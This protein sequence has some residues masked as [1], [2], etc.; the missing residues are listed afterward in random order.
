MRDRM[1]FFL[2]TSNRESANSTIDAAFQGANGIGLAGKVT[3]FT[4]SGFGRTFRV[5]ANAG[6]GHGWGSHHLVPGSAVAG[7]RFYG[8]YPNLTMGG[9]DD[10]GDDGPWIPTTS[11]EQYG[12][13]LARWFGVP[14][15]RLSQV[16]PNLDAFAPATLSFLG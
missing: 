2:R 4:P 1:P 5:K 9:P 14:A 16:L 11:M 10:A 12:V 13:T 15:A 6:N 8:A 3:T 7:G